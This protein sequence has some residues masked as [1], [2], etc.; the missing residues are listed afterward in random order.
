MPPDAKCIQTEQNDR[1]EH[2]RR[3]F[4]NLIIWVNNKKAKR[5]SVQFYVCNALPPNRAPQL[6][7][8][9]TVWWSRSYE[10]HVMGENHKPK[11]SKS[12]QGIRVGKIQATV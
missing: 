3:K 12:I 9:D 7:N 5:S 11:G 4:L 10:K 2:L 6:L 1:K 8:K